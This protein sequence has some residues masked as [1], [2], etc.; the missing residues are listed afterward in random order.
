MC[1]SRPLLLAPLFLHPYPH[2][3]R[4]R[5]NTLPRAP[6]TRSSP[7]TTTILR[8]STAR[9][10]KRGKFAVYMLSLPL[11]P[12]H[13][14]YCANVSPSFVPDRK[15]MGEPESFFIILKWIYALLGIDA[16]PISQ[17]Q[18]IPFKPKY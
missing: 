13:A 8:C 9:R 18:T 11:Y 12:L 5:A 15:H 6:K 10:R 7:S 1:V 4:G 3:S 2:L 14:F 16:N 17:L